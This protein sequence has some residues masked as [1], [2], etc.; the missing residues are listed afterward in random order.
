MAEMQTQEHLLPIVTQGDERTELAFIPHFLTNT[1]QK[2][3]GLNKILALGSLR[4]EI[5]TDAISYRHNNLLQET[6][7]MD[8]RNT[9]PFRS[10]EHRGGCERLQEELIKHETQWNLT[11]YWSNQCSKFKP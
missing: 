1:H 8:S 11:C 10:G 6:D 2:F 9:K 3:L 4:I 5:K 7:K